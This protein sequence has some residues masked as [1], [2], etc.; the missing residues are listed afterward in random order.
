[1]A[2]SVERLV[3][4]SEWQHDRSQFQSPPMPARR[5]MEENG[6][7]VILATNKSSGVTLAVNLGN[8]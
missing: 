1:M 6:L 3:S 8:G 2:Q 4:H 5:Y 7:A